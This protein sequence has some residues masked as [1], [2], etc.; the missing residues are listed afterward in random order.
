MYLHQFHHVP[1][2]LYPHEAKAGEKGVKRC[3][4]SG[5]VV[6]RR[7]DSTFQPQFEKLDVGTNGVAS[8]LSYSDRPS[9]ANYNWKIILANRR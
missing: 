9:K 3:Q 1:I 6:L 5:I 8:W 2:Q 7:P 4:S